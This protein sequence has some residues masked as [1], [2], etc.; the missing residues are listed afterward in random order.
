MT[1]LLSH[2][3]Q[4]CGLYTARC[5]CGLNVWG[6]NLPILWRHHDLHLRHVRENTR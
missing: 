2:P 6:R 1:H 4:T 5:Q 3:I